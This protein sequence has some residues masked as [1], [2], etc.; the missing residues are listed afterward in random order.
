MK[1]V[2][3][4]FGWNLN[5]T[6]KTSCVNARGIPP[7][8]GRKML[9]PPPRLAGPDPPPQSAH[10]PDPPPGWLDLTPPPVGSLTWPPPIGSL[11]W[12]PPGWTWPPPVGSLTWP[13]P[14]GSAGPD[15]PP[16]WTWPPPGVDRQ[17]KWNYYLPVVLRTRA[18]NI[19][20]H[21][22]CKLQDLR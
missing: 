2:T 9:T 6:R 3:P 10:W 14:P 12:P 17:T 21:F 1:G 19:V 4:I 13:P 5:T 7:E 20:F 15:P 11:T 8:R 16:G 22:Q 18:V